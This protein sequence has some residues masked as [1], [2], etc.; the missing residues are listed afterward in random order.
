MYR[1]S[2]PKCGPPQWASAWWANTTSP[3]L[4]FK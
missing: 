1:T 2:G 4:R 3:A